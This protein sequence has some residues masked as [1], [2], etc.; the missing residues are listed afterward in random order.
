MKITD[1]YIVL[2]TGTTV[3][4]SNAS[5]KISTGITGTSSGLIGAKFTKDSIGFAVESENNITA[6]LMNNTNG[7]T[8][9][10]GSVNITSATPTLRASNGSYVRIAGTGIDLGSLANLYINSNNFKL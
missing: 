4:G 1:S 6:I 3:N 5:T 2:G 7:I 10:S 9:G 8:I